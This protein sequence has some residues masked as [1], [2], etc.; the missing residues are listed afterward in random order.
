[1]PN[2]K[3][4][5]VDMRG[6]LGIDK[7]AGMTSAEVVAVVKRLLKVR[8]VGHAG[9]LD[10]PATGVLALAFGEAT[11]TIPYVMESRKTYRFAVKFGQSTTTDDA[12]GEVTAT[13]KT[14]PEKQ[15]ILDALQEFRGEIMQ[16]PPAYSAVKVA[17]KRAAARAASGEQI[18]L[19]S[20]PLHVYSL[21][22]IDADADGCHE[23]D[24][25]C[26]KGG[27]VRSI[28]RDLGT[29][30][31]CPAH[32]S[33]LRRL[34]AGPFTVD[35]CLTMEEIRELG[36]AGSLS[37]RLLPLETGLSSVEQL[38]CTGAEASRI[39]NGMRCRLDQAPKGQPDADAVWVSCAGLAVATGRFV[40][41]IFCPD[42]VFNPEITA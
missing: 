37:N 24:F 5:L 6:W 13:S 9:T 33:W 38:H 42:R 34:A 7:P 10:R 11:K 1:M 15:D 40:D 17:G 36:A 23:F 31:G 2:G 29:A 35:T 39:R 4:R 32:V 25:V 18:E 21:E 28:A 22:L 16:R 20:R 30:V 8:K 3:S 19:T 27:Y 14:L 26:G 12:T 41:G